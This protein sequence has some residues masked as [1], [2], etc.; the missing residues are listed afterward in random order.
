[1]F[2]RAWLRGQGTDEQEVH[3]MRIL[4]TVA[5]RHGATREIGSVVARVL[6]EA[7]HDVDELDPEMVSEVRDYDAVVLG[8]AVYTAH[9]LPAARALAERCAPD[10]VN[11]PVWMLSSGLATQ[12]AASANSPHEVQQLREN[13]GARAHRS[14]AGRLIR[15]ELTFAERALISGAR[16]REGDHRDLDAVA[17]WAGQIVD[18]LAAMRH[19]HV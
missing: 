13:L 7:G 9:W 8:S 17:A 10:L 18:E 15:S 14:F 5:S 6:T 12:P 11:R 16:A 19:A 1:M 4:V 2:T 3:A